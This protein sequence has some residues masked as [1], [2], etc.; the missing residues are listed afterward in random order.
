MKGIVFYKIHEMYTLIF[1]GVS[2]CCKILIYC[3]MF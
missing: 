2:Y 1:F 3:A